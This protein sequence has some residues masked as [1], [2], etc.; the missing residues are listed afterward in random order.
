MQNKD[1]L[2]DYWA[3]S[4]SM[5]FDAAL[6]LLKAKKY[7]HCLFFAH[8]SVEKLLK[9]IYVKVNEEY[10]PITHNLLLLAKKSG[11]VLS[12]LQVEQFAEINTFSIEARYPDEKFNFYKKCTLQFTEKYIKIIEETL[13]WLREK[14]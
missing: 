3:K 13:S 4:S 7:P 9:A 12:D 2:I 11:L 8:L 10:S 1:K 5:D 6:D 14:L